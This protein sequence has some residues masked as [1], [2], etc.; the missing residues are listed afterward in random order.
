MDNPLLDDIRAAREAHAARFGHD[1][2]A[3]CADLRSWQETCGH[4][5]VRLRSRPRKRLANEGPG[6]RAVDAPESDLTE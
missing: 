4:P 6:A 1:L 3:I 2:A 5:V